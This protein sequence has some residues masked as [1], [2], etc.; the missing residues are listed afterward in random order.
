M[1]SYTGMALDDFVVVGFCVQRSNKGESD[2][3]R[4][5]GFIGGT[6]GTGGMEEEQ[7]GLANHN[8]SPCPPA[9]RLPSSKKI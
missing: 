8:L 9:K 1:R 4:P 2:A 5:D 3:R 6:G 7:P